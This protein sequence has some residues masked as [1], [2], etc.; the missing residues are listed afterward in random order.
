MRMHY[1]PVMLPVPGSSP[2]Q[3]IPR[4]GQRQCRQ[5]D[6]ST[7][8]QTVSNNVETSGKSKQ[9]LQL[10]TQLQ[11]TTIKFHQSSCVKSNSNV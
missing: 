6:V 2:Q 11:S 1:T 7:F 4:W 5:R 9:C 8:N 10:A 3:L